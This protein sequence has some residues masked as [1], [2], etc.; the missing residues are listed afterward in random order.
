MDLAVAQTVVRATHDQADQDAQ[1]DLRQLRIRAVEA[2]RER[3][4]RLI[5]VT[6]IS[7][8]T[9]TAHYNPAGRL[10]RDWYMHVY[11][12][13]L[14]SD[15]GE[16][17]V[18]IDAQ[19]IEDLAKLLRAFKPR[20]EPIRSLQA[21]GLVRNLATDDAKHAA[22]AIFEQLR[23]VGAERAV[24]HAPDERFD[25]DV[26]RVHVSRHWYLRCYNAWIE[27]A[28]QSQQP[29]AGITSVEESLVAET[30]STRKVRRVIGR[31]GV[32]IATKHETRLNE[33][34]L[35][36]ARGEVGVVPAVVSTKVEHDGMRP[37]RSQLTAVWSDLTIDRRVQWLRLAQTEAS[38]SSATWV[39]LSGEQQDALTRHYLRT[40]MRDLLDLGPRSPT[41]RTDPE[42][43][44]RL[45]FNHG[46]PLPSV[47][48]PTSHSQKGNSQSSEW[49]GHEN[50]YSRSLSQYR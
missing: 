49:P 25:G 40:H 3:S 48:A 33:V 30:L 24:R 10:L 17:A 12:N 1:R 42:T 5:K 16:P 20:A 46:S 35:A 21:A 45:M 19:Q 18:V 11:V 26:L 8:L 41:L 32:P 50:M 2:G 13:A 23:T 28:T 44:A 9:Q 31:N 14:R 4:R 39:E 38:G 29:L 6:N 36:L 43:A 22:V 27:V 47:D 7:E 37:L 15:L 34:D